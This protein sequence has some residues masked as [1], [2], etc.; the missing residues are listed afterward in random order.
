MTPKVLKRNANLERLAI[1]CTY[2]A[3][4]FNPLGFD[5]VQYWLYEKTGSLWA[6]NLALYILAGL[7]FTL[8]WVFRLLKKTDKYKE[9]TKINI[10]NL[11]EN[12]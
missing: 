8:S 3:L 5:F 4:F 6:A 9:D 2:I 11:D 12:P 7:F 10:R 1:W